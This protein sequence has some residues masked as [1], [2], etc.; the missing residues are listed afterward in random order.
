M[1]KAVNKERKLTVAERKNNHQTTL[2][3]LV[4]IF[5]KIM[6]KIQILSVRKMLKAVIL[7]RESEREVIFIRETGNG[8][9]KYII[10]K[11]V[12]I[13]QRRNDSTKKR[14]K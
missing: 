1:P 8:Q 2:P 6:V 3:H 4:E 5:L 9:Q 11:S 7:K 12:K 10:K 13:I 14:M